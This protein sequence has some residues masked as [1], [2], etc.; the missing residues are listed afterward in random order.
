MHVI[1]DA[2]TVGV[3]TQVGVRVADAPDSL[4]HHIGDFYIGFSGDFAS[5]QHKTCRH[6]AFA[7]DTGVGICLVNLVQHRI[8]DLIA[9]LVRMSFGNGFGSEEIGHMLLIPFVS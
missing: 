2:A 8:G 7:G 9:D 1:R 3:E 6:E 5:D 4:A